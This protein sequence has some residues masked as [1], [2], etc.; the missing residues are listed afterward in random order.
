M[1]N[2]CRNKCQYKYPCWLLQVV[3]MF[4]SVDTQPDKF[5]RQYCS[6]VQQES[7]SF[8][9]EHPQVSWWVCIAYIQIKYA[10]LRASSSITYIPQSEAFETLCFVYLYS[11][12]LRHISL[13]IC[14]QKALLY[15]AFLQ[16]IVFDTNFVFMLNWW[17]TSKPKN[18]NHRLDSNHDLTTK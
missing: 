1:V 16:H 7:L 4:S 17:L 15:S 11:A 12:F 2:K 5:F 14:A 9:L 8:Y 6:E 18:I 10:I 13:T 3:W